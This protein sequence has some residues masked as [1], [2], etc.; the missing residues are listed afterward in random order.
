MHCHF[1]QGSRQ[2]RGSR[3]PAGLRL[4]WTRGS[5][6]PHWSWAWNHPAPPPPSRL[7]GPAEAAGEGGPGCPLTD[8]P[9]ELD[10]D[11]LVLQTL[12]GVLECEAHLPGDRLSVVEEKIFLL[13]PVLR[14]VL[15][16][17]PTLRIVQQ[18]FHLHALPE[19]EEAHLT[20][21]PGRAGLGR[22]APLCGVGALNEGRRAGRWTQLSARRGA[23]A[24]LPASRGG[25]RA[26][27]SALGTSAPRLASP[28]R[29]RA[30]GGSE[31]LGRA[32]QLEG[33]STEPE[34]AWP[35]PPTG[36]GAALRSTA[37]QPRPLA[38]QRTEV[39]RQLRAGVPRDGGG[40]QSPARTR[41]RRRAHAF[42]SAAVAFAT[43]PPGRCAH[44][45]CAVVGRAACLSLS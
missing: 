17:L 28:G 36:W 41:R 22:T 19:A 7:S 34:R 20:T 5:E 26:G 38:V 16:P 23:T 6:R 13:L 45:A 21:G 30:A 35:L 40:A 11:A 12:V 29:A 1:W 27:C 31:G 15:G 24:R 14:L 33:G 43:R 18:D 8:L 42:A 2:R 10:L 25:G 44:C 37:S 3:R 32:M 39:L 4:Q 9:D